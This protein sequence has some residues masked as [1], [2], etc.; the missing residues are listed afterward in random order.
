MNSRDRIFSLVLGL[1]VGAMLIG[2]DVQCERRLRVGFIGA[3]S[4]PGREYGEASK[5]GFE[6]ARSDLGADA[7]DV[8]YEDD[9]FTPSKTVAA[10]NKLVDIDKVDVLISIGS[11][12]SKVIAPLAEKKK[13]PLIAWASD[14][15][16][17]RGYNFVLRSW[18]SGEQE[19]QRIAQEASQRGYRRIAL[20]IATSDYARS[21]QDG[22]KSTVPAGQLVLNEEYDG[23]AQDFKPFLLKVRAKEVEALGLCVNPGQSGLVAKQ[24]ISL[25][26]KL[27]Y[28]G[29]EMLHDK[30]EALLANG[31]L[32]GAW[33]VTGAI[34]HDFSARYL[35]KVGNDSVISGAAIHYDVA[36]LVAYASRGTVDGQSLMRALLG[37]GP[38]K[39]A[40]GSFTVRERDGDRWMDVH[41]TVRQIKGTGFEDIS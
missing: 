26:L 20:L 12:P 24:A 3:F 39:G 1:L 40:V 38:R 35:E 4:G 17:A 37:S 18:V 30:N 10:F 13:V 7:F 23:A 11:S 32:E 36:K 16:V 19:G 28:F 29:C 2:H 33:F 22:I 6:L 14:T 27:A 41:L 9:Q 25:G 21:V 34:E 8:I 31:A 15:A 5:N